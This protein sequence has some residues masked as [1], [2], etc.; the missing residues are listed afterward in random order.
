MSKLNIR[1][2]FSVVI[3]L[4]LL[5]A[6][7]TS[8]LGASNGAERSGTHMVSG[9]RVNLDHYRQAV[10]DQSSSAPSDSNSTFKEGGHGCGSE[11]TKS[12]DD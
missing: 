12:P 6:I 11:Q 1:I 10:P 3:S 7:Y 2:V 8:V 4:L 5:T 9:A